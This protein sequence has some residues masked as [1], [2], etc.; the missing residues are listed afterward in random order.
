MPS[1]GRGGSTFSG[2]IRTP[3]YVQVAD[4]VRQAI[5]DGTIPPGDELPAERELAAEFGVSRATVREALRVLEA[6]GLLVA[7]RTAPFKSVVRAVPNALADV[8]GTFLRFDRIS[9]FDLIQFRGMLELE[10]VDRALLDPG[11]GDWSELRAALERMQGLREW[12]EELYVAYLEF[13]LALARCSGNEVLHLTL[14]ATQSSLADHLRSCFHDLAERQD[15]AGQ[16]DLFCRD[17][18]EVL[19]ALEG[20]DAAAARALL[21]K[22]ISDFYTQ[23]LT[24]ESPDA[25]DR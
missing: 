22:Q 2:V 13:H 24:A 18:A 20:G 7:G 3:A 23:V 1:R 12:S 8:F 4:Q 14:Q 19:G 11:A 9:L 5:F 16:F 6:Q 25:P 17:H 21:L 15:A 10:A